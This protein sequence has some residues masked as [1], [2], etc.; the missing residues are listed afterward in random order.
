MNNHGIPGRR[1]GGCRIAAFYGFFELDRHVEGAFDAPPSAKLA[2]FPLQILVGMGD[3]HNYSFDRD[4]GVEDSLREGWQ[5]RAG[6]S[7][8]NAQAQTDGG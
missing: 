6:R 7:A 1:L 8:P 4:M 3:R 5:E 2:R